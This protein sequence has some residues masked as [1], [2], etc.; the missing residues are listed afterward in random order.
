MI[1]RCR[2][3]TVRRGMAYRVVYNVTKLI[4]ATKHI[5]SETSKSPGFFPGNLC[6]FR[7]LPL[8]YRVVSDD[9][10]MTAGSCASSSSRPL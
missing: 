7:P 5:K 2:N 6:D 3:S 8:C 9:V 10:R 4:Y 1:G